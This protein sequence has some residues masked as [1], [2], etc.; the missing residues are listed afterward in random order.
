MTV[1][2]ARAE[3]TVG[4]LQSQLSGNF[5]GRVRADMSETRWLLAGQV[6][7]AHIRVCGVACRQA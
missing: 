5:T 2:A 1:L 4:C 7:L 6:L 3:H